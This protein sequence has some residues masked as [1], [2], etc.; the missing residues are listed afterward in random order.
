MAGRK[1]KGEDGVEKQLL[2]SVT[3]QIRQLWEKA[4]KKFF[5]ALD[6][7]DKKQITLT[8]SATLNL[9]ENAPVVDVE[10][11]FKDKCKE[12]GLTVNKTYRVG[13][14]EQLEDPTQPRL[15]GADVKGGKMADAEEKPKR[16][17]KKNA[18]AQAQDE[19]A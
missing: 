6:D 13:L 2:E 17:G 4:G 7:N 1:T 10:L 16:G 19:A 9:K 8:F 15:P 12:S 5:D 18:E 11:A 14:A 3:S